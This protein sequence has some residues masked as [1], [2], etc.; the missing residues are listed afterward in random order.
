MLHWVWACMKIL[1]RLNA[2]PEETWLNHEGYATCSFDSVRSILHLTGYLK[3]R[4]G[5][6]GLSV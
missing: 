2:T 4:T 1:L 6:S 5:S 3:V